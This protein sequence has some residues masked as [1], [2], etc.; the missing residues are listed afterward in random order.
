MDDDLTDICKQLALH[1]LL[2][3]APPQLGQGITGGPAT[4]SPQ[5]PS[6]GD[7]KLSPLEAP[8]KFPDKPLL[9]SQ[10][11]SVVGWFD[12][13]FGMNAEDLVKDLKGKR[14]IHKNHRD[15]IDD[16]IDA[17]RLMK[18]FEVEQ[19]ID[20]LSW[21]DGHEDTIRNL[22]LSDRNLKSLQKFGEDRRVSLLRACSLW[23]SAIDRLEELNKFDDDWDSVQKELWVAALNDKELAR[24]QW[25]NC[26]HTIDSLTKQEA[27]W[28]HLSSEQLAK[29][30]QMDARSIVSNLSDIGHNVRRLSASSLG[31]LLKI[32]GEEVGIIKGTKRREWMLCKSDGGVIIKD[33]WAYAA[34]FIDADGYITITKRGEPRVG[35]VATG[36]RGRTHC[37]QLHK[38]LDCGILQLDLK[39]YKDS[40]RSQH[41]L[42]FYSKA[43][44]RKVLNGVLPHI[45]MKKHQAK[46]VLEYITT[47]HKGD[48]AKQRRGQLEKL[49][50]WDNWSDTKGDELLADWGVSAEAVETWRDP[51][52]IRLAIEAEQLVESI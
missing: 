42:Q 10:Q 51:S 25:N 26:L 17:I 7:G 34:G 43:D 32:Y 22:G 5:T 14:R 49:V 21:C 52:L 36:D 11:K 39:V 2:K 45:R 18:Q 35:L 8:K 20:N 28:M 9:G 27:M 38:T 40:Q 41:R 48:I 12:M 29:H 31:T 1:P 24:K 46:S 16:L 30:G 23:Q 4:D 19:T 15:E 47:P 44:I 13:H 33:P 6:S 50:K 3:G 37:E